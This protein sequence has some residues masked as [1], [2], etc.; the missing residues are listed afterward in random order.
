VAKKL[1]KKGLLVGM[2][3]VNLAI[4]RARQMAQAQ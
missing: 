1:A 2:L 4:W 3:T